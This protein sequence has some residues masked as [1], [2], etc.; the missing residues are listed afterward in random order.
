MDLAMLTALLRGQLWQLASMR[1]DEIETR[2]AISGKGLDAIL[3]RLFPGVDS[4]LLDANKQVPNHLQQGVSRYVRALVRGELNWEWDGE[5][6][7]PTTGSP[8]GWLKRPGRDLIQSLVTDA[9]VSGKFAIFPSVGDGGVL[10]V[11]A[12][13]GFLWPIYAAGDTNVV[14]GWLQVTSY[15]QDGRILYD[16]RRY[17]RGLLEVFRGL[18]DWLTFSGATPTPYP[19]PH[20]ARVLPL[21]HRIV[22]RDANRDPE[23]LAQTAMPAFENFL[24]AAVL[25]KFIAHRGGFEERVIKSDAVFQLAKDNPR[26]ERLKELKNVGPNSLRVLDSGGSY[27]R[28]SPVQLQDYRQAELDARS[29]VHNALNIPDTDGTRLSGD[30]LIEKRESYS[31]MVNSLAGL[32]ADALTETHA[33]VAALLPAQFKPGWRVT[34]KPHFAHDTSAER[35]NLREDYKAGILPESAALSGLQSLGVVYVTEAMVQAAIDREAADL[36]PTP[37]PEMPNP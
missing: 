23:G 13:T 36:V 14:L 22:G 17:S 32:L 30:A 3:A 20:A 27:E 18:E 37:P 24:K 15:V 11:T 2:N 5:G 12:L 29:D 28:L 35:T 31:E 16:V 6:D 25:L 19:Q 34:L 9:L 10:R 1:Y 21:T 8:D 4:R 33:L 7:A 26:D